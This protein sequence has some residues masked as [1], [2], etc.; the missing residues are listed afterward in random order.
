[1]PELHPGTDAG[2]VVIFDAAKLTTM[3]KDDGVRAH[4]SKGAVSLRYVER[5]VILCMQ[6]ERIEG[7]IEVRRNFLNSG[8]TSLD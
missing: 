1:M 5:A 3:L 2:T 7:H 8:T 4:E 6:G